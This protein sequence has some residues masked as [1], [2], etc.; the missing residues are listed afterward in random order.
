MEVYGWHDSLRAAFDSGLKPLSPVKGAVEKTFEQI[1]KN[2]L[3]ERIA[4][5][6]KPTSDTADSER[7]NEGS[8]IAAP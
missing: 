3:V 1:A 8:G 7:L 2:L 6:S 4:T 5:E